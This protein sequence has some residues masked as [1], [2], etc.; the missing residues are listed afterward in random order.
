MGE[1]SGRLKEVTLEINTYM[2]SQEKYLK[3]VKS[4]L[5]YPIVVIGVAIL[6]VI[7]LM[8][9]LLPVFAEMYG[10]MGMALPGFTQ[11]LLNMGNHFGW[12]LLGVFITIIFFGFILKTWM[13]S[14][15]FKGNYIKRLRK[16]PIIGLVMNQLVLV[17]YLKI[18]ITLQESGLTLLKSLEI[19]K[20]IARSS[21]T[22]GLFTF[23]IRRIKE[24]HSFSTLITQINIV[25]PEFGHILSIS[26]ETGE[27]L[28]A[29]NQIHDTISL[30][31]E[32]KLESVS[33]LLEPVIIVFLG[34]LVG[35]ILVGMYLPIFEL[36]STTSF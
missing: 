13:N 28:G 20:S 36:S 2:D 33:S 22:N 35:A 23:I 14:N 18:L 7:F 30:D 17:Y 3:K 31:L 15:S 1:E 4:A 16:T 34:L 21:F 32:T 6:T 27:F 24:G 8:M 25:E 11:V 29:F 9:F 26:E 12:V 19:C 5:T 10:D